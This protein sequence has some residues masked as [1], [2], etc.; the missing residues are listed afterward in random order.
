ML[1]SADKAIP[2]PSCVQQSDPLGS[3]LFTL[4]SWRYCSKHRRS[5]QHL[6]TGQYDDKWRRECLLL[7]LIS[8]SALS[9]INFEINLSKSDLWTVATMQMVLQ[10]PSQNVCVCTQRKKM[11][12]PSVHRSSHLPFIPP[13]D[14]IS[15]SL[16]DL[17][18]DW[19]R[20]WTSTEHCSCWGN[21]SCWRYCIPTTILLAATN[22]SL[23]MDV[24]VCIQ[25]AAKEI[26]EIQFNN[27]EGQQA[28]LPIKYGGLRFWSLVSLILPAFLL[29]VI[30]ECKVACVTWNQLVL[31][32]ANV[33]LQGTRQA[34][35]TSH[36]TPCIPQSIPTSVDVWLSQKKPDTS[37]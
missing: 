18:T 25:Q 10:P 16:K 6:V 7:S 23:L 30:G 8:G 29:F 19:R 32:S 34:G 20:W 33:H 12:S 9:C 31:C 21:A 11:S 4:G 24:D 22:L 2:S 37:E 17:W 1:L 27:T 14:L 28:T 3:L 15:S 13:A 26:C 36:R 35:S 5:F